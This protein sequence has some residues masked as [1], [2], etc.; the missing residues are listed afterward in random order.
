MENDGIL[1][2]PPTIT[3]FV[4]GAANGLPITEINSTGDWRPYLPAAERQRFRLFD[5]MACV[6]FSALNCIEAQINFLFPNLPAKHRDFLIQSGYIVNGKME[7]S[8]RFTAKESGTTPAGNYLFNV[9]NSVRND[10]LV[11]ESTWPASDDFVWEQYYAVIPPTIVQAG[12]RFTEYFD[13]AY[14]WV[15]LG[16][17]DTHVLDRPAWL[18]AQLKHAPIQLASHLT[19]SFGGGDAQGTTCEPVHHAYTLS[20]VDDYYRL[21]DHYDPYVKRASLDYCM[22]WAMKLVVTPKVV[23]E[24]EVPVC[25]FTRDLSLGKSGEDVRCLQKYLNAT[26]FTIAPS[27][28]GSSGSETTYYGNLTRQSVIRW[29]RAYGVTPA[30]GYFGKKSRAKYRELTE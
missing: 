20:A 21:F 18:K 17:T 4:A 6:S 15:L 28:P 8:D 22:L 25:L 10:G 27:G 5:T 30:I 9:A 26:G 3:D 16:H 1:I 19:S 29:Q 24:P 2:A 7:T 12:K 23:T 13:I 11:P 14:E